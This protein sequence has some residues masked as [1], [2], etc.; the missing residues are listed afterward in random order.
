MV[1]VSCVFLGWTGEVGLQVAEDW[2]K[3]PS[4]FWHGS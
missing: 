2:R 4:N 3:E 1:V